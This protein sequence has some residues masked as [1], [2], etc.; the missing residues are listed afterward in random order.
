MVS[1]SMLIEPWKPDAKTYA[2]IGPDGKME[3]LLDNLRCLRVTMGGDSIDVSAA[4]IF[5]ALKPP[6]PFTGPDWSTRM[7]I[8]D[9]P[10]GVKP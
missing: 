10:V 6:Q 9:S 1:T 8:T 2:V 3:V 4:E 7:T 5:E